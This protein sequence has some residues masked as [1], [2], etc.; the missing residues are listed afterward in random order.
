MT[1]KDALGACPFCGGRAVMRRDSDP[2]YPCYVTFDHES[3]CVMYAVPTDLFRSF[4]NEAE[5]IAAWNRRTPAQPFDAAG[6]REACLH[7]VARCEALEDESYNALATDLD[8]HEAGFHRGQKS[9]AKALRREFHDLTR[10]LPI[11]EAPASVEPVVGSGLG[12]IPDGALDAILGIERDADNDAEFMAVWFQLEARGYLWSESNVNKAHLGWMLARAAPPS[13]GFGGGDLREAREVIA[14]S[15]I[16]GSAGIRAAEHAKDF[17]TG[18][19]SD[20]LRS[21]DAV[22]A[23]LAALPPVKQSAGEALC[24]LSKFCDEW[25]KMRQTDDY[26][27]GLHFG[28]ERQADLRAS[29]IRTVV[30]ALSHDQRGGVGE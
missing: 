30:A 5:A 29:D 2:G 15:V 23:A 16:E 24:R 4:S 12:T 21:A 8:N 13:P 25:A 22:I 19:W 20:A 11:P 1:D 10:A 26:I 7:I 9:T 27:H 3:E 28:E 6:V 17:Q 14:Y 18:N